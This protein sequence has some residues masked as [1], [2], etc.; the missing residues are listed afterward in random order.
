MN[1]NSA[2]L[3]MIT[4][5]ALA[6]TRAVFALL[7]TS[8]PMLGAG[9]DAQTALR[10]SCV[11]DGVSYVFRRGD[12]VQSE[13]TPAGQEDLDHWRDMI[14]VILNRSVKTD[15]GL[16]DLAERLLAN[17]ESGHGIVLATEF[18]PHTVYGPAEHFIAVAFPEATQ[19]EIA[20]AR[21]K[22]VDGIACVFVYSHREYG[23][24][25]RDRVPAWLN[26][27]APHVQQALMSWSAFPRPS[28]FL[29]VA[30]APVNPKR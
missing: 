16:A 4:P 29:P 19:T 28:E 17:Y 24:P 21:V 1:P 13:F 20:C 11:F 14:A 7:F 18:K 25:S 6:F 3:S 26:S 5:R 2:I 30:A 15:E 10:K 23:A 27:T 22:L 8:L 9:A 12:A